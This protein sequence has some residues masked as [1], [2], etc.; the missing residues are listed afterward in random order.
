MLD[1]VIH[2]FYSDREVFVR[3]LVS[4][5]SDALEKLRL[6]QL[7]GAEI[8]DPQS[9]LRITISADEENHTLTIADTGIGMTKEDLEENLD[10][11]KKL[12]L[13]RMKLLII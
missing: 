2:A 4:N 9:E 5:A 10:L 13:E 7:T 3:E 1:I 8:A 11:K 12:L 6:K